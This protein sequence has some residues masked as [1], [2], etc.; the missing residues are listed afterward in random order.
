MNRLG[1]TLGFISFLTLVAFAL[2]WY[3]LGVH[4]LWFDELLELDIAQGPFAEIGPQMIRHAAMPLDYYLLYGWVR[5]GRQEEW[6]RFLALSFGLLAVPLTYRLARH[7]FNPRTGYLAATLLTFTFFAIQYSQETRPYALLLLLTTLAYLGLWRVYQ[8]GRFRYWT[9]VILALAAAALTH[10]FIL[11]MLLPMGLFVALHQLY[12]LKQRK[13]WLHTTCFALCLVILLLIFGLN[14]RLD[15]LRSVGAR[16]S[17]VVSQPETLTLSASE[18]PNRGSG[19]PITLNFFVESVLIPLGTDDPAILLLYNG[20]F[21]IALLTLLWPRAENRKAILLLL[22]WLILPI[23]LIYTFLLQRGTFFAVRYILYTLPAYLILVVYALDRLANLVE[24]L[25]QTGRFRTISL[26]PPLLLGLA[27]FPLLLAQWD[28]LRTYYSSDSREDWRAV[29]R[30]LQA[31]ASPNDAVIAVRAEPTLNWYYPLAQ[32]PFGTFWRSEP[33]WQ[34]LN[35]KPRRWF[36][37]SSYSFRYDQGLRGWLANQQAVKIAIDR[38]VEVYFHQEG[39][40][41]GQML[42]QVKT[43]ALPQKALTYGVLADQFKQYGDLETSRAFY[44]KAVELA[45]TPMQKANYEAH[46]AALPPPASTSSQ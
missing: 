20:F 45:N 19:P 24:R 16:F 32:R 7:L 46:L 15:V 12:R 4:S 5:L 25:A 6:V 28:Q 18:K 35:Q 26:L 36:V 39:Q 44:Q 9:L 31:E 29:G 38:R 34:A 33:I 8:T 10:F 43:F 21:L 30:L 27:L 23:I 17:A 2:R 42:A 3:Q 22:G 13:F 1:F 41:F 40:S 37:L 14:G 11:F